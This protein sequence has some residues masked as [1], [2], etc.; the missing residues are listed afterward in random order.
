ML[1]TMAEG[2][3]E[4]LGASPVKIAC[5]KREYTVGNLL[6]TGDFCNLYACDCPV[7]ATSK[8]H[9]WYDRL[10]EEDGPT[11]KGLLKVVRDVKDSDLIANEGIILGKLFPQDE[12]D[13]KFYRYL[14]RLLERFPLRSGKSV[15]IMPLYEG[16]VP[17]SD[18]IKAFPAGLD[19]RDVVWMFKRTLVGIGFAHKNGVVHGAI[20]PPHVLVHPI[21]HGA[22]LLDWSFAIEAGDHIHGISGGYWDYYPP[23]VFEKE[24]ALPAT[25]IFMAAKCVVALLGGNVKTNEIPTLVPEKIRNFFYKCLVKN[26]SR[27]PQDAWDLHT[28]FDKLLKEVV[29]KPTYRKLTMP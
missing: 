3:E 6:F 24:K 18:V 9:T 15:S 2:D 8:A 20:L 22:K 10:L 13:A 27:R 7:T 11:V 1:I 26:A 29:G 16:Y 23:E 25:D 19:F 21:E 12:E 5:E 17:L 28:E 14:P 4:K